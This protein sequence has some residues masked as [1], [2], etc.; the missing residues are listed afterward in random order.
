MLTPADRTYIGIDLGTSAVKLLLVTGE[1]TILQTVSKPLI[2]S[3]PR[4]GWSEQDPEQ[5]Y[6][7]TMAGLAQ[8]LSGQDAAKVRGLSVSGQMHGLV[9]LDR[10]D[11]VIRPAILWNDGRAGEEVRFFNL[12]YGKKRLLQLVGNPAFA[13]FTA[14]KLLWMQ[15]HEPEFYEQID[16]VM[17]P[18]DYLIF[19]LTGRFT[20]DPSDASGTLLYDVANRRWST[21]LLQ[22]CGL[23]AQQMPQ[24]LESYQEVGKLRPELRTQF[25]LG[26]VV[27]AAGAGDNAAAAVGTGTLEEGTCMVSLGTSGTVFIPANQF[28]AHTDGTLHAFAHA[29]GKYH[30][31]GCMLSAAACSK[32]W[33]ETILDRKD[34]TEEEEKIG[35]LGEN[36]VFFCLISWGSGVPITMKRREVFSGGSTAAQAAAK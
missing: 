27:V 36:Q 12:V 2:A 9:V 10:H 29:N 34:Y 8:L 20:S 17:L 14:P 25:G 26:N 24:V 7:Q 22:Q 13:G 16:K 31:M 21:E 4:P 3:F 28:P 33:I 35:V 15:R 1:G 6:S 18:K 32:W 23:D 19:R 30:L 5:W 11:Q